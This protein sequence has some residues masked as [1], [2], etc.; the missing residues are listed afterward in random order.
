M[1]LQPGQLNNPGVALLTGSGVREKL[2]V[3]SVKADAGALA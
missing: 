2:F 1:G 3:Q